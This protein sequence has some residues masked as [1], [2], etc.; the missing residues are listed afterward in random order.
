MSVST[1]DELILG[2]ILIDFVGIFASLGIGLHLSYSKM[3]LMLSH[4]KNCPIIMARTPLKDGGPGGRLLLLGSIMGLLAKPG[5]ALRDGGASA[6]D[7][8]TFPVDIKRKLILI[9]RI[10]FWLLLVMFGMVAIIKLG[11]G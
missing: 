7:I 9:H 5:I 11:E 1:A 2:I 8:K 6:A 10:N 3:D 4:L